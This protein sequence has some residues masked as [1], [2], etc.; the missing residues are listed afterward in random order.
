M[1]PLRRITPTLPVVLGILEFVPIVAPLA[2]SLG[3][4]LVVAVVAA[5][6]LKLVL[7]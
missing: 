6:T 7:S 3:P 1:N 4:F 5:L 2:A